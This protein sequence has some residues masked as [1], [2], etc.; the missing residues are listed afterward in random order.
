MNKYIRLL[1]AVLTLLTLLALIFGAGWGLVFQVPIMFLVC[2]LMSLGF[3]LFVYKD[4][5]YYFGKK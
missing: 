4:Y 1:L 2:T 5:K 3:G